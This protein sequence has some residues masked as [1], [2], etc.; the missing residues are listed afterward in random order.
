MRLFLPAST[1]Y[2]TNPSFEID[3][4]DDGLADGW[5]T[6]VAHA[7]PSRV[8]GRLGGYAQRFTFDGTDVNL[9]D[10]LFTVTGLSEGDVITASGYLRTNLS[11]GG[12]QGPR[13]QLKSGATDSYTTSVLGITDWARYAVTIAVPAGSTTAVV[14]LRRITNAGITGTVD[15]DD[16]KLTKLAYLDPYHDGSTTDLNNSCAWTGAANASTSTRAASALIA[17]TGLP[18]AMHTAGTIAMKVSPTLAAAN[19]IAHD[20]I[21]L[22][23]A[24]AAFICLSKDTANKFSLTCCGTTAN[25]V[26]SA[27]QS[28]AANSA[29]VLVGRWTQGGAGTMDLN[30][31]G[32]NAAQAAQAKTLVQPTAAYFGTLNDGSLASMAYEGPILISPT[33]KPDAW[34]TAIQASS[35]AAYSDI[36]GLKKNFMAPGDALWV[37]NLNDISLWT[38]GT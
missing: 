27:A 14:T 3:T 29:H 32:T 23:Q 24:A 1:N 31:D 2:L 5:G 6:V 9:Y 4:N 36:A 37:G 15:Y 38:K 33:R 26:L 12:G 21:T 19:G 25:S 18:A 17:T 34:V 7:T 16:L 8:A 22:H 28:Y 35:G 11:G 10:D 30:Y 20:F 13:I